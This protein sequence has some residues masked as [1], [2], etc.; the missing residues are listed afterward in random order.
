LSNGINAAAF[1]AAVWATSS[2]AAEESREFYFTW[3]NPPLEEQEAHCELASDLSAGEKVQLEIDVSKNALVPSKDVNVTVS[4]YKM[5]RL[6]IGLRDSQLSDA[7]NNFI[8]VTKLHDNPIASINSQQGGFTHHPA[9]VNVN[10]LERLVS[11]PL[12]G[13]GAHGFEDG[14]NTIDFNFRP[15]IVVAQEDLLRFDGNSYNAVFVI[16]CE[17]R[18]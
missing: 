9:E 16:T 10:R 2:F 4:L 17:A 7:S 8:S 5:L 6:S 13:A 11:W 15:K 18:G 3:H 14:I 12:R 1:V